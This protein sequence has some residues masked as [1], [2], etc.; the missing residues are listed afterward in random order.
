MTTSGTTSFN[1]TVPEMILEAFDNLQI[2]G[3]AITIEHLISARRSANLMFLRWGNR[4]VNLWAVDLQ[5]IP[6]LQGV[7][8]YNVDAATIMI[9]DAYLRSYAM[10]TPVNVAV[11]FS[12]SLNSPTVTV[13]QTAHGLSVGNYVN[14]IVPVAVGGLIIQ[15]FY[16][17]QSVPSANTFTITAASNATGNVT[18]GGQVP[19]FTTTSGSASVSVS[20]PAHALLAGQT[21]TVQVTTSVGGLVLSGA[22]TVATVTNANTFTITAP[23]A[24]GFT[25]TVSENGGQAQI[26]DQIVAQ[27]PVDRVMY[28][29]SRTDYAALPDKLQQGPPTT[30]WYDRLIAQ[31]ATL[32]QVP[33]A[34]GPYAFQFYRVRQIQDFSLV[35]TQSPEIPT[36]F[37]DAACVEL[38]SRLAPKFAPALAQALDMKAKEAWAEAAGEDRERVTFNMTPDFGGYFM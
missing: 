5:S 24:A 18:A 30:F 8:T 20:L 38:S 28:P 23:S 27:D 31:T 26:A 12:T 35:G 34:N 1:L 11:A 25:Q 4:G 36:R 19:A 14:I 22:Y 13:T 37:Y 7:A 2:R 15:G 29:I 21:F 10:N 6:L 33:D 9:L 3:P 32:W 17:V 16:P